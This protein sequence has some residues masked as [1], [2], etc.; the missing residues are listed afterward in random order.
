MPK[1]HF[2]KFFSTEEANELIPQLDNLMRRMQ[3]QAHSLRSRVTELA[4]SEPDILRMELQEI[5]ERHP[6]LRSFTAKLAGLA[7]EIKAMGCI[8]KDIEQGLIDFPF[9]AGDEVVLLCWQF[10]EPEIIAWHTVESGFSGRQP[11][12]G[13]PKQYL[14]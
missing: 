1:H 5:V 6:E 2:A 14:N 4:A 12:P 7:G 13:V 9:D 8:L 3:M 10:G 11:L